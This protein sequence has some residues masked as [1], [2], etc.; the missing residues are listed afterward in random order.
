MTCETSERCS[1]RIECI[2]GDVHRSSPVN[3]APQSRPCPYSRTCWHAPWVGHRYGGL[4]K[5]Q[6]EKAA[7]REGTE[8][9][10]S[11]HHSLRH[12]SEPQQHLVGAQLK[13]ADEQCQQHNEAQSR[14]NSWLKKSWHVKKKIDVGGKKNLYGKNNIDASQWYHQRISRV[15]PCY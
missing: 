6:M 1:G 4:A 14:S 3:T 7:R 9:G 10:R 5:M 8:V 15:S 13:W 2:T 12:G 11:Q